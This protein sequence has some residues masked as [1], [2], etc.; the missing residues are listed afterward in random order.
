V[1]DWERIVATCRRAPRDL[2]LSVEC[3]T[4]ED[5]ERSLE[6]LLSVGA[7]PGA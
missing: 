2:V 5:A 7:D 6:H 4:V 1:I 3:G